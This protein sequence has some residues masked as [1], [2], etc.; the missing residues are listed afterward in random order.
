MLIYAGIL[1]RNL[2]T[3]LK[4]SIIQLLRSYY[5]GN[6]LIIYYECQTADI[7]VFIS[8]LWFI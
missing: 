8:A 2:V 1:I 5:L 3:G 4:Y 6:I 7:A